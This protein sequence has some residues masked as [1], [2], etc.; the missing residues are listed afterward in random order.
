MNDTAFLQSG[1]FTWVVLPVLI[2][3][4]RI[5]DVSIGTMRI[6]Y[7]TR[8][9]RHLAPLL[10]FF[11]VTIWLLAM[12]QIVKHL[13]NVL[14]Y[15]A[16][17]GGYAM[18]SF[19]GI[20]LEGK[21]AFGMQIVRIITRK[22]AQQ[23]ISHLKTE[24]F[25]LTVLD[26]QG[27]SGPVKIIFTVIQRRSL[28]YLTEIIRRYNPKSFLSIEDVRLAEEAQLPVYLGPKDVV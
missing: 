6:I 10:G 2:F 11:E 23:L 4:A 7:V 12:G 3:C 24:G 21:L 1:W 16:Y 25:G 20:Y 14:C 22:D 15:L 13:D 5:V 28:A 19:V 9:R 18:G 26:G 17:G 8:G 27:V